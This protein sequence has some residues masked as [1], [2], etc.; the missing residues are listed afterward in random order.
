[1]PS[2]GLVLSTL[3]TVA[4]VVELSDVH[5][6]LQGT[7]TVSRIVFIHTSG[8]GSAHSLDSCC[9]AWL[10]LKHVGLP[11]NDAVV[12]LVNMR[13]T[14]AA[15]QPRP[16]FKLIC[17][18]HPKVFKTVVDARTTTSP[19]TSQTRQKYV[20]AQGVDYLGTRSAEE[21]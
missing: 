19:S 5:P 17:L 2:F 10:V 11:G 16:N 3:G 18:N 15:P 13:G 4:F 12:A 8:N 14:F 1:M 21:T 9:G 20:H 6:A 7:L